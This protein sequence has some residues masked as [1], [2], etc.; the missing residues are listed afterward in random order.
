M[1][2]T[3]ISIRAQT[4]TDATCGIS[5]QQKTTSGCEKRFVRI[6]AKPAGWISIIRRRAG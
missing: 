1:T 3:E 2:K 4:E 5:F 6:L